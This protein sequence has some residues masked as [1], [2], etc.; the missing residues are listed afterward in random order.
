MVNL[1]NIPCPLC[2]QSE[3]FFSVSTP[4]ESPEVVKV[5][6]AL[7]DGKT[8]SEW[9]I[10]GRCGFV[11]LNPRPSVAAIDKFYLDDQYHAGTGTR[12]PE[13]V[14][15]YMKFARWYYGDKVKYAISQFLP[16]AHSVFEIGYGL[17]ASLRIFKDHGWKI[18]GVEPDKGHAHFA[19][20][21]LN[22]NGLQVGILDSKFDVQEKVDLVFSNHAV[23]HASDLHE[24]IRGVTK[25]LKPGGLI[26]TVVP[27]YYKNRGHDSKR[28]MNFGHNSCFTGEALNQLLAYHGFEPVTYTYRAWWKEIDDIWHVARYTGIKQDPK[29][30]YE[31]PKAVQRYINIINPLRRLLYSPWY[32]FY[33]ARVRLAVRLARAFTLLI[34]S[35]GEF[36]AKTKRFL[37]RN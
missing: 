9:K 13:D 12:P 17:G 15:D 6:S 37:M 4:Q 27:T 28:T 7:F 19:K 29:K 11:H 30:Y 33:P 23:E 22:L 32:S 10:C 3:T 18:Y 2:G 8:K 26:L 21:K 25:V 5:Y 16:G 24:V 20:T 1:E 35:P 31:N 14:D 36:F 34:Q